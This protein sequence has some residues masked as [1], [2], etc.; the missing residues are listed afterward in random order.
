MR[1]R[2]ERFLSEPG[3]ELGRWARFVRF[4]IALWRFCASRLRDNNVMAM[5]AA[6]SFR[7]IFTMIPFLVLALLVMKSVGALDNTRATLRR[8]LD[9]SGFAQIAV[10]TDSTTTRPTGGAASQPSNVINV[11]DEIEKVVA[12]VES[13]LTF[14]RIGPIG[15]VLLVWTALT[16]L[17][18]MERSLNR[19]FDAP[20]ARGLARRILL[21]W[22]TMTLG[23]LALVAAVYLGGNVVERF[24]DVAGVGWILAAFGWFG[25]IVVGVLIL[26]AAYALLPNTIVHFRAALGGAVIAVPLWL[27]AKWGFSVYVQRLVV[28]GN[29]YGVLGVLPL[30]LL[31]LNLSWLIFLF[32]AELAHTAANLKGM[33][34]AERARNIVLGPSDVL[35]TAIVVARAYAA[36]NG[37]IR[38]DEIATPLG[39]PADSVQGLIERLSESGVVCAVADGGGRRYTMARA[40]SGVPVL[41]ILELGDPRNGTKSDGTYDESIARAVARVQ[42]PAAK[43]LDHLTLA[44]ALADSLK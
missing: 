24:S 1:Q 11:A 43:S 14:E 28:N 37:P 35:A 2:I 21:Y 22:S 42:S 9:A 34:L 17:T 19:I 36:G 27:T 26:S 44:D 12:Q 20:R 30:F 10:V 40:A 38:L 3:R 18:T 23:P 31:W 6:L 4:Q 32:G 25:P 8:F 16:L 41:D 29:L 33:E 39:L 5:S 15:G 7:T 13:K